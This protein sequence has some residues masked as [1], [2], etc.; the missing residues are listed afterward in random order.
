M[1]SPLA[2]ADLLVVSLL[3]GLSEELLFRGGLIPAIA[4]DWRGVLIA[5]LTF[6]A[7]H[8]SGG[9]YRGGAGGLL[10]LALPHALP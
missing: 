1:L 3:P 8:T 6:G 9:R 10:L 7:L 4:P 2:P 5:G